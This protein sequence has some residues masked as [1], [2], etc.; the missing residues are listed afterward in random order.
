[1]AL[2]CLHR[3]NSEWL[4]L[5]DINDQRNGTSILGS[6]HLLTAGGVTRLWWGPGWFTGAV[7]W[8]ASV[9]QA[10]FVMLRG[11][12]LWGFMAYPFYLVNVEGAVGKRCPVK[13]EV[14]RSQRN[15]Q[16]VEQV[17]K[18]AKLPIVTGNS[19]DIFM[20]RLQ[21]PVPSPVVIYWTYFR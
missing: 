16:M 20:G 18:Q 15:F 7:V 11:C 6:N 21:N 8:E 10:P 1:M 9:L 5:T 2:L 19:E 3:A 14:L 12:W 17:K 13:Y 4:S